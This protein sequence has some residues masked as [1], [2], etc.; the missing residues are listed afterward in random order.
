MGITKESELRA[1]RRILPA[2][3]RWSKLG[4][5]DGMTQSARAKLPLS[6]VSHHLHCSHSSL[7][8]TLLRK[9]LGRKEAPCLDCSGRLT[10]RSRMSDPELPILEAPEEEEEE[11]EVKITAEEMANMA[12]SSRPHTQVDYVHHLVPDLVQITGC[13]FYW[14][15]MDRYE[16]EALLEG[17]PEGSFLLRD[18]AQEEYLFSVSFRRY[19]RSLHARIE[20]QNHKFSFDCHDPGVFMSANIP[21]LMEHYKDP[22]SCMFFEPMLCQ[23]V[24]RKSPFSLQFLARATICDTLKSYSTVDQLELPKSLKA[25]L[26]EYHYRHKARVRRLDLEG[27]T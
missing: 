16:A 23:A 15:K 19:G 11:E 25:Y 26:K 9:L 6:Q 21:S 8:A 3:R 7:L 10:S 20:E 27:A 22:A 24:N 18:S 4:S 2:R 13:S 14:G 1:F 12:V 17:R 5:S